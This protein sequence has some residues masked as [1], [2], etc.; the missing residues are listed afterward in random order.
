MSSGFGMDLFC[1]SV[2]G[3]PIKPLRGRLV[4]KSDGEEL[5][6]SL[7]M[8]QKPRADRRAGDK[9]PRYEGVVCNTRTAVQSEVEKNQT[10]LPHIYATGA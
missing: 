10:R 3:L 9:P 6:M 1:G 8:T 2:M 4:S 7:P 5:G